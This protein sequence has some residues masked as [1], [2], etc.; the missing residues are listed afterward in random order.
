[1]NFCLILKEMDK[2]RF[3]SVLK[4]FRLIQSFNLYPYQIYLIII[5]LRTFGAFASKWNSK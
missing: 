4:I 3:F 2:Y 5:N 1:M